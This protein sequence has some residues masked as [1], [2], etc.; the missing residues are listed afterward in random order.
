MSAVCTEPQMLRPDAAIRRTAE[1][2][3][4]AYC[5]HTA[6]LARLG[7]DTCDHLETFAALSS[8]LYGRSPGNCSQGN[9]VVLRHRQRC[10]NVEV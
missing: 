4:T 10:L 8:D 3:H 1:A 7:C 6:A 2:Q 9:V 5:F